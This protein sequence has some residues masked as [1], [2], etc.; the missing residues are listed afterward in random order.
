MLYRAINLPDRIVGYQV[1]TNR[2]QYPRLL[3]PHPLKGV[4]VLDGA[5][6]EKANGYWLAIV[7][8]NW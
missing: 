1:R 8:N 6:R 2:S 5:Q 4:L 3:P 7:G